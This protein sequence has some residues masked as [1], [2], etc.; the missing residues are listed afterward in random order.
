MA[1]AVVPAA[2]AYTVNIDFDTLTQGA[3]A[4]NDPVALANGISFASV[5]RTEDLDEFGDPI[6]GEFHWEVYR[7]PGGEESFPIVVNDP[8]GFW[9]PPPSGPNAVDARYD[10]LLI[11]FSTPAV[12]DGFSVAM[13]SGPYGYPGAVN[14][15]LLNGDG[16]AVA[17]LPDF[18]QAG[19]TSQTYA[20]SPITV[21]S[22]L[23][24]AGKYYDNLSISIVPVPAAVWLFGSGLGLLGM[25]RRKFT[26]NA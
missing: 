21:S 15:L 20:F 19:T 6:A 13:D 24:P 10:Q 7:E 12:L 5:F 17:T 23:V 11:H 9:G 18:I 4:N 22:V 8:T 26:T 25:M 2:D 14:I 3:L 16:K 1:M